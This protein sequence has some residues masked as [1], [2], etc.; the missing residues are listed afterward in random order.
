MKRASGEPASRAAR[1]LCDTVPRVPF[2]D[3]EAPTSPVNTGVLMTVPQAREALKSVPPDM[4]PLVYAIARAFWDDGWGVGYVQGSR[5]CPP[6]ITEYPAAK[7]TLAP[8]GKRR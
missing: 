2:P 4:Q 8:L 3:S 1:R 5:V 7:S 6:L